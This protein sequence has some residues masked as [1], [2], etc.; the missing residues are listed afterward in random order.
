MVGDRS[1]WLSGS[2]GDHGPVRA[3]AHYPVHKPVEKSGDT[4]FDLSTGGH[5][6]W[7]SRC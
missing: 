5:V 2:E 4:W 7:I 3:V 1:L 6:P